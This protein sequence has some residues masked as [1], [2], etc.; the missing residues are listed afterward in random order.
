[1]GRVFASVCCVFVST[2][3][4]VFAAEP[5]P[6]FVEEVIVT[7]QKR[8][9]RLQDVPISMSVLDEAALERRGFN[10]LEDIAFATPNLAITTPA[11]AR[12]TQFTMRGITGQTFFPGTESAVGIFLDGVYVNNPI[13]Q[14][15]DLVDVE[16]IEVL[17]GPQGTLYGKNTTA[18]AISLVTR[19][20]SAEPTA[21]ALIEYGNYDARRVRAGVSGPLSDSLFGSLSAGAFEREGYQEN[22]F[23]DRDLG[24]GD[25]WNAR[26]ALRW[27]PN[28][29]L[30]VNLT[31]D[32]FEEDRTPSTPDSTPDDRE[33]ALDFDPKEERKVYGG[34]LTME[35]AI[36]DTIGLTSITAARDYD[37]ERVGDNDLTP[38]DA[39]V[40]PTTESTFQWS[41][42]LRLSS[43]TDGRF[44][45]VTGLYYLRTDLDGTSKPELNPDPL[46]QLNVGLPCTTLMTLSF[47][48]QGVPQATAEALAAQLCAPGVGDNH[49][50]QTSDTYA[51][52]GETT[53]AL[54]SSLRMTAGLRASRET[55]DFQLQQLS[56]EVPLFLA[57]PIDADFKR[58]DTTVSP[59]VALQWTVNE[60]I[61][62]YA[63][64]AQGFKSGGF[65]TGT[66]GAASQLANTEFDEES[67]WSYE[68]G[69]K[70][71]W[72]DGRLRV[73]LAAFTLDYED[74]QVFRFE[75]IAS[76]VFSPRI[77]NAGAASS[78]GLEADLSWL[79]TNSLQLSAGV[80]YADAEYDDFENCGVTN[81]V[82]AT[83]IDCTGN[84]LTNAPDWT[85]DV[86]AVFRTP[87]FAA[88]GID[89]LMNAEWSYRGQVYYDVFNNDDS[90]QKPFSIWNA[91]IGIADGAGRWTALLY[92]NNVMDEEYITIAV[93]GFANQRLRELGAPRTYGLRLNVNL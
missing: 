17:R 83:A 78:S 60:G 64:A 39:F 6:G 12:T 89:L 73:D 35:Y 57:F 91:S 72:L 9:Q 14:N 47:L 85:S 65:N 43:K 93:Q 84:A 21:N 26:G 37:H 19:R 44:Q 8:E 30:E 4:F 67:L 7:A 2:A 79:V 66:V 25:T 13:A 18:G 38:L 28:D 69:M 46:F 33:S 92:G 59:K 5:V 71:T 49:I 77:T 20:P 56:A 10:R 24:T 50:D 55:K 74:L 76:G 63:T 11:D 40:S 54:T 52:F 81:T 32:Y 45:W 22:V 80:G 86:N 68:V 41:E 15:F 27:L 36:T 51:A 29:H 48:A 87:L 62:L 1:M 75:E 58:D 88:R 70:A 3:T 31:A 34:A 90:K 23:L 53:F 82:P 16:R 61:E 42:E